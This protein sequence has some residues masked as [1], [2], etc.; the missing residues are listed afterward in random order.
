MTDRAQRIALWTTA[1]LLVVGT[2]LAL[3]YARGYRPLTGFASD[4]PAFPADIGIR[5]DGITVI[6]R[7]KGRPA[8]TLKA[9]RVETTRSRDRFDFSGG[10]EAKFLEKGKPA[11][12]LTAPAATYDNLTSALRLSGD[13][14]CRIRDLRITTE[15]LSWNSGSRLVRCPGLVR[16]A[17]G[18]GEASGEQLTV[19]IRTRDFALRNVRARFRVDNLQEPPL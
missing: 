18:R 11:A 1:L 4:G 16:A 2:G 15:A 6:G 10:I 3:R 13:I 9:G 5:F 19:D 14:V 12:T 17:S 8:W 7:H